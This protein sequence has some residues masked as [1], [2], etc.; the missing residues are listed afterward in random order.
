[1]KEGE[2]P[3][4][5]EPLV[6]SGRANLF[7]A[8]SSK[9]RREFEKITGRRITDEPIDLVERGDVKREEIGFDYAIAGVI[10]FTGENQFSVPNLFVPNKTLSRPIELVDEPTLDISDDYIA[11]TE[12]LDDRRSIELNTKGEIIGVRFLRSREG[13]AFDGLPLTENTLAEARYLFQAYHS[14][15]E[16]K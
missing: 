3:Q 2:N 15:R 1:M 14:D 16:F 5:E 8:T 12:Q 6:Q 10:Y 9:F 7:G 13:V 11:V 4:T